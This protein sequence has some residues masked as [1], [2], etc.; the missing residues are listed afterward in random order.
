MPIKC[1]SKTGNNFYTGGIKERK[2]NFFMNMLIVLM[3]FYEEYLTILTLKKGDLLDL[4]LVKQ[5]F[6][7]LKMQGFLFSNKS[8]SKYCSCI[9][10]RQVVIANKIIVTIFLC[11]VCKYTY[12][13]NWLHA[14]QKYLEKYSQNIKNYRQI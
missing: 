6:F 7:Y 10:N 11:M 12:K 2:E 1:Y 4:K 5:W 8:T 14:F 13:N 3:I 9:F